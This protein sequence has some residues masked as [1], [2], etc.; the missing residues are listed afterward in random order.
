VPFAVYLVGLVASVAAGFVRADLLLGAPLH[1]LI[2]AAAEVLLLG[3]LSF[4]VGLGIR[5]RRTAALRRG[6]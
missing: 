4:V 6:V 2:P 3:V 1:V 5:I